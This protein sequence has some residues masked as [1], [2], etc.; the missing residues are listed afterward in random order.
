MNR[1]LFGAVV[2]LAVLDV[3]L[4]VSRWSAESPALPTVPGFDPARA[5]EL[6]LGRVDEPIVAIRDGDQWRLTAPSEA[7]A[8]PVELDAILSRLAGGIHPDLALPPDPEG[9]G[10]QGGNEVRVDV[11][12]ADG[13][14]LSVV[15]GADAG[16]G[17]TFVRLPDADVVY[18]APIGGR[19]LYDR[20]VRTLLDRRVAS[21]DPQRISR[22]T[23][24]G[25]AAAKRAEGSWI[26]EGAA[27][28][29][30]TVEQLVRRL[31]ALRGAAPAS[32]DR[33]ERWDAAITLAGDAEPVALR[34]GR[35][36]DLRYVERGGA[37]WRVAGD[38]VDRVT[39]P[40]TF[41]DRALWQL[42]GITSVAVRGGGRDGELVRAGD[43]WV[44]RRPA[45]V[46]VDP[47]RARA[48]VAWLGQ[49]R[50]L[51]WGSPDAPFASDVVLI[52]RGSGGER[53]LEL[54]PTDGSDVFVRAGSRIGRVDAATIRSIFA[55]FGG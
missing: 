52:V 45:N 24:P 54:G 37:V 42:D 22:V 15:V 1:A 23:L 49:P 21:C 4:R 31:C 16:G 11:L 53:R 7:A 33:V 14:L 8:D 12:G 40:E 46:D 27:V 32:A 25:G 13:P 43:A 2:A 9:Y 44:V 50:V 39:A 30:A 28:D 48:V 26:G 35:A 3:G 55:I 10:L 17:G 47:E 18:R 51:A 20:P 34:F 19:S 41:A 38:W 5:T 36:G 6:R 29:G